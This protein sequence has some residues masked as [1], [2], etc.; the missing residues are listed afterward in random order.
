MELGT[1]QALALPQVGRD[2]TDWRGQESAKAK[3]ILKEVK[4]EEVGV[5]AKA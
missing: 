2:G 5:E 3:R 1:G 4:E